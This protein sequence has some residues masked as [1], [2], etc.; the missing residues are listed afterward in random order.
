MQQFHKFNLMFFYCYHDVSKKVESFSRPIIVAL[1]GSCM[2]FLES[3]AKDLFCCLD[4][5]IYMV[6]SLLRVQSVHKKQQHRFKS[7]L[8]AA[9]H[10]VV[11]FI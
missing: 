10:C 3:L 1:H 5:S 6:T 4:M 11:Y 8:S 2:P 7:I 9:Q